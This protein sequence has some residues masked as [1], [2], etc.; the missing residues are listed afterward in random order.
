MAH[1]RA[2]IRNAVVTA[3]TGLGATVKATRKWPTNVSELP[4][5]HV[6]TLSEEMDDGSTTTQFRR[7]S[8]AVEIIASAAEETLDDTL[9]AFAVSVETALESNT[10]GGLVLDCRLTGTEIAIDSSGQETVGSAGLTFDAL[11]HTI[12]AAPETAV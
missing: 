1:V 4:R 11:Y 10:L 7:L 12:R 6:Y 5:I 8:L 9:D 2:Q 3:V